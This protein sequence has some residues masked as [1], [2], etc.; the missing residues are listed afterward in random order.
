MVWFRI[1]PDKNVPLYQQV[2]QEI[3]KAIRS[4]ALEPGERLP[5]V[6][7]LASELAINPNTVARAYLELERDGWIT[8]ARGA[9]TFVTTSKNSQPISEEPSGQP[10]QN[11]RL[12]L[13]QAAIL[14][15]QLGVSQELAIAILREEWK[16][17][18]R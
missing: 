5:T 6:R 4:G 13:R 2:T 11:L 17:E 7:Q 9:G 3:K 1:D 10:L 14:A 15:Q 18:R 16:N 12:L 8:T